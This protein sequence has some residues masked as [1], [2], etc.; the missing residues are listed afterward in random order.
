MV[1]ISESYCDLASWSQGSTPGASEWL[2]SLAW[3]ARSVDLATL[4]ALPCCILE[5][6][7]SLEPFGRLNAVVGE[8]LPSGSHV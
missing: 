2:G 4:T 6:R 7:N 3:R 1:L 5:A 8:R